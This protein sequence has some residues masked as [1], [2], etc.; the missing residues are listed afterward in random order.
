MGNFRGAY[1]W[2]QRYRKLTYEEKQIKEKLRMALRK[3]KA[4]LTN[5]ENKKLFLENVDF[6]IDKSTLIKEI[7]Q[8]SFRLKYIDNLIE[9]LTLKDKL[10]IYLKYIEG[11]GEREILEKYPEY[12]SVCNIRTLNFRSL[13]VLAL[14]VD[15]IIFEGDDEFNA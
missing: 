13:G 12:K 4:D 14:S 10:L 3:Y 8:K 15:P 9:Y 7:K 5:I 2:N 6:N 1:F 11:L